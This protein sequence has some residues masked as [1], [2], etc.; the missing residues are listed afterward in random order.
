MNTETLPKDIGIGTMPIW[1]EADG[2]VILLDQRLLPVESAVFDATELGEM[3]FAIETM[4]VRGAPSIGVAAAFGLAAH[5]RRITKELNLS[6]A[7]FLD[8][9]LRAKNKLDATRPTAV[10]LSWGTEQIINHARGL[11]AS[12]QS[13]PPDTVATRLLEF[14]Q[15][16]LDDHVKVNKTLSEFGARVVRPGYRIMTHCN[17]GSLA[18]CGWGTALG[19]IRSA[20][21]EGLEPR[22]FVNETRPRNQGS[23][24]TM[25]ELLQDEIPSTLVCDS[26]AG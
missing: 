20:H 6:S 16:I 4:V 2:R 8:E 3:C 26:M 13:M 14:A 23:K 15:K 7:V 9:L 22:V 5:A 10:N 24:L 1:M 17:A 18:A 21:I 11:L 19:V 25:W 12:D